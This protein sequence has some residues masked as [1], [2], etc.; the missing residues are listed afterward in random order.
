VNFKVEQITFETLRDY[1]IDVDHFKDPNKRI[2]EIINTLGPHKTPYTDPKRIAY[3]LFDGEH[4][5]GATQLVHWDEGLIRYRTINV[6]EELR[7]Q[8]LGWY[9]L[10]TAWDGD[11]AGEGKLFGWVRDTH[12]HWAVSHGFVDYDNEWTGDHIAM[13]RDMP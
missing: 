5:I 10:Q 3:G 8:D 12:Y 1:W 4:L 2:I 11:W 6:R 13:V 7:G 9:L